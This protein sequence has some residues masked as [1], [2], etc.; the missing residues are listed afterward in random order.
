R[1]RRRGC[2]QPQVRHGVHRGPRRRS[3]L[4]GIPV[5]ADIENRSQLERKAERAMT[6]L[7]RSQ[8]DRLAELLG[9][10]PDPANVPESFWRDVEEERQQRIAEFALLI[11]LLSAKQHGATDKEAA[12]AAGARYAADRS[13]RL[14][15]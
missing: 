9:D 7:S 11:W 14:A 10:P 15:R 12:A 2:R 5:M 13:K 3:H 1:F 8:R 6:G 4:R